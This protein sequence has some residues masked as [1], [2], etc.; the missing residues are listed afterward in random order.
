MLGIERLRAIV[1]P[2]CVM[3]CVVFISILTLMFATGH[4]M[5][6][7]GIEA[8]CVRALLG[9]TG[10]VTTEYAVERGVRH[11]IKRK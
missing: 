7:T 5:P 6:D 8:D 1:R 10:L 9:I 2:F 11:L 3:Y 4:T